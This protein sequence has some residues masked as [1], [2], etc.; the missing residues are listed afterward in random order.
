MKAFK[1]LKQFKIE[2]NRHG[3]IGAEGF[4]MLLD[5]FYCRLRFHTQPH[6]YFWYNFQNRKNRERRYFFNYYWQRKQN[7]RVKIKE[8]GLAR[9]HRQYAKFPEYVKR[10]YIYVDDITEQ[11]L[12]DFAMP[13]GRVIFKPSYGSCGAGIFAFSASEGEQRLGEIYNEIKG[14]KYLCEGYIV[15]HPKMAS[16]YEGSVNTLR[17]LTLNDGK[18][19]KPIMAIVRTGGDKNDSVC[20]NVSNGGIGAPVDIETGIVYKAGLDFYE[21]RHLFHP[22]SGAKIIGFNIPFWKEAIAAVKDMGARI[23]NFPIVGWDIAI[24]EDG[25][26]FVEMNGS[27]DARIQMFADEPAGKEIMAFIRKNARRIEKQKKQMRR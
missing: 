18:T 3:Y 5:L 11:Q 4:W 26:V 14:Q 24:G 10:E 19:V 1:Y 2:V 23:P 16:L 21:R 9:K 12:I 13:Q 17:I 6:E 20:D 7:N 15:Q 25:P 22:V 8:N 27:S